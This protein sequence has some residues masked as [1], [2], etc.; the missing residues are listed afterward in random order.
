MTEQQSE[1]KGA[2]G[3]FK[4]KK[5]KKEKKIKNKVAAHAMAGPQE[6]QKISRNAAGTSADPEGDAL[7]E[8]MDDQEI[9]ILVP[10][11]DPEDEDRPEAEPTITIDFVRSIERA[12]DDEDMTVLAFILGDLHLAD[13]ADLVEELDDKDRQRLFRLCGSWLGHDFLGYLDETVRDE[14]I[15][16]L[17]PDKLVEAVTALDSDDAL[18]L[19][20]DLDEK[21]RQALLEKLPVGDRAFLEQSLGYPEDSAGR[22]MQREL[23]AV[24]A[25]WTVG[26]TI[27]M[28]RSRADLPDS[29]YDVFVVDPSFRPVGMVSVSRI[30]RS[31]RAAKLEDLMTDDMKEIPAQ[32]DQEEVAYLFRQYG[33]VEAPVVDE[34]G[35]L[36]GMVT[37]DDVVEVIDEEAEEDLMRLGGVAETDLDESAFKTTRSRFPWLFVNLLT[38]ILASAVIAAFE[39]TIE[40]VVVLAV[41]MPIVASMGGNAGTQALTVAVRAL[42]MKEV[43]GSDGW[44]LVGKELLVGL[45]NGSLF[46]LVAGGLAWAYAG[47]SEIGIVVAVA[48]V[49]N[50]AI[51]GLAGA[52]IPLGLKRIGVDPAVASAVFLTTVTDVVGF[53]AFLGLAGALLL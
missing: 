2:K 29:F 39:A 7:P 8:P 52:A 13:L 51:A 16:L 53:F 5:K 41:I 14:V 38:A 15:A 46:A 20:E 19:V 43:R 44:H 3:F 47:K 34:A 1:T 45:F 25:F 27:D 48:M 30:L 10:L 26:E 37:V 49:V 40:A 50:L 28:M 35:R 18:Y 36:I 4:K 22:L 17:G 33:L 11:E 21:E 24:P 31:H 12:L 32:M 42:A 23:V 6:A 9:S